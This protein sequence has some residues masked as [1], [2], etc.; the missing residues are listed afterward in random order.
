MAAT[1]DLPTF[2]AR[3]RAVTLT[4]RSAAQS[5]FLDL[6]RLLGQPT[7]T[8]AD[9][10]GAFYTFEKGAGKSS[11]GAGWADVWKGTVAIGGG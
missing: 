3:W 2:V 7:P 9:P 8:E 10:A 4:E 1:L 11:G 6:C 5:H